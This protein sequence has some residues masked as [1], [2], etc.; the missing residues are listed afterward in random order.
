[1]PDPRSPPAAGLKQRIAR[2]LTGDTATAQND[3]ADNMGPLVHRLLDRGG[4]ACGPQADLGA[5]DVTA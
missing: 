3:A 5:G 1:M 4:A 2:Q